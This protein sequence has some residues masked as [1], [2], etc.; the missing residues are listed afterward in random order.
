[1]LGR[2][3]GLTCRSQAR[4]MVS[5]AYFERNVLFSNMSPSKLLTA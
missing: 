1:V 5:V 2:F 3:P 4:V